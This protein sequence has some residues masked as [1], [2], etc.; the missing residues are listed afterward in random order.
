MAVICAVGS[1]WKNSWLSV[2]LHFISKMIPVYVYYILLMCCL[3]C[4]IVITLTLRM[5]LTSKRHPGLQLPWGTYLQ[6]WRKPKWAPLL[7][8][9]EFSHNFLTT[10]FYLS[11]FSPPVD[12][13]FRRHLQQ[14]HLYGPLY[15]AL[16]AVSRPLHRHL[17]P[18]TTS[19]TLLPHDGALLPPWIPH[20][21]GAFEVVCVGCAYYVG[22]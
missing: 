1:L 4:N 12:L 14:V 9:Q 16:S 5:T 17:R 20:R 19:G 8:R 10:L 3:D 2:T 18:F 11:A 15:I 6:C 13:Y 7:K 21:S 22:H